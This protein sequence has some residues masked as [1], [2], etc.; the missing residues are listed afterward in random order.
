M[1]WPYLHLVSTHFP[2]VLTVVGA[3]AALLSVAIRYRG[4]WLFTFAVLTLAGA[5]AVPVFLSGNQAEEVV[6]NR[7]AV[8]RQ[9]LETH[10]EGGEAAVWIFGAMGLLAAAAWWKTRRERLAP[11]WLRGIVVLAALAGAAAAGY[12]GWS[13]G[14]IS[15]AADEPRGLA[16]MQR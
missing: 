4:A 9:A 7:A 3:V 11:A 2:I 1:N 12:T 13:G 5:T 16:G 15:H 6:E 8:V 10:E 14:K